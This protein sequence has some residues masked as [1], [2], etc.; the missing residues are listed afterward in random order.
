MLTSPQSNARPR[1]PSKASFRAKLPQRLTKSN[2]L[3]RRISHRHLLLTKNRQHLHRDVH[4][5]A[6]YRPARRQAQP[7]YFDRVTIIA[8]DRFG[9]IAARYISSEKCF[10]TKRIGLGAAC[11]SPQIDASTM[12]CDSSS[13]SG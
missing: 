7:D 13:S 11:P 3:L 10:I 12:A 4:D 6:R 2:F 8:T 9:T 5:V 1:D